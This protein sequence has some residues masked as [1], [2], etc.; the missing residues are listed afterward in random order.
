MR[1]M[2]CKISHRHLKLQRVCYGTVDNLESSLV[3][4]GVS[5]MTGVVL[6]RLHCLMKVI[7]Y[8]YGPNSEEQQE[9]EKQEKC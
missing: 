1:K 7:R 8:F 3:I 2:A 5:Q 6:K 9:G 4:F